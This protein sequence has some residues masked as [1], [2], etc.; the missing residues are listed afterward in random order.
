MSQVA[1]VHVVRR[2]PLVQLELPAPT[3]HVAKTENLGNEVYQANAVTLAPW[4]VGRSPS[5]GKCNYK[6]LL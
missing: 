3:V 4:V 5:T 2:A 6:G 1:T